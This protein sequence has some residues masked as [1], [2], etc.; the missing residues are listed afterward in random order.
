MITVADKS[1]HALAEQACQALAAND[2]ETA[3]TTLLAL[4]VRGARSCAV[5]PVPAVKRGSGLYATPE[6]ALRIDRVR[7][8]CAA[9]NAGAIVSYAEPRTDALGPV[10]EPEAAE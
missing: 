4:Y 2:L 7:E 9:V 3:E 6:L 5:G 8:L 1:N 10:A